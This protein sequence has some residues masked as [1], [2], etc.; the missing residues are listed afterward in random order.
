MKHIPALDG[1][2]A[3]AILTVVTSHVVTSLVPGGFGVTLFF[4]IS[5]FIIT[6]LLLQ[7]QSVALRRF[8]LRRF[9]RLG[10]ALFVFLGL[11]G[12]AMAELGHV[13]PM[14]DYAASLLYFANYH[15]YAMFPPITSP[16]AVTWSLAVEEHFYML[17][18]LV[19][20][21]LRRSLI[22]VLVTAIVGVLMW[23]FV[24]VLGLHVPQAR[25][26]T[27]TDTRL[28]SIAWGCLLAAMMRAGSPALKWAASRPAKVAAVVALAAGFVIRNDTFRE[29]LRY[30]LQA[31]AFFV[32]FYA[33]FQPGAR[34]G[35]AHTVLE[36]A[37]M[38]WVGRVSYSLY[39]YHFLAQSVATGLFAPGLTRMAFALVVGFI[40]AYLSYRFI[41]TP[42][43]RFGARLTEGRPVLPA[44]V[45]DAELPA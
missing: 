44:P 12:L 24:L 5:G 4:F 41:E 7:E 36:S 13:I 19:L 17:F 20:L 37:P 40:G 21:F 43:R 27:S 30:T 6:Q 16:L 14:R 1:L 33:L 25:T 28:D 15:Q 45:V 23:R 29:T 10:P 22:P 26:Y 18:P 34:R 2:R 39:L 8:Y 32:A 42:A 11:S 3:V 9:F 31:F 35:V 38:L